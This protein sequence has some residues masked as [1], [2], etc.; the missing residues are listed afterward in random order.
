MA[1]PNAISI[2]V[3]LLF[4]T[5]EMPEIKIKR[6]EPTMNYCFRLFFS[7]VPS[8]FLLL[9]LAYLRLLP[10]AGFLSHFLSQTSILYCAAKGT[11]KPAV[12][13][14]YLLNP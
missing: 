9:L 13:V 14:K 1:Q 12:A 11:A 8:F 10:S 4:I 6:Q 3:F 7:S 2:H 5:D